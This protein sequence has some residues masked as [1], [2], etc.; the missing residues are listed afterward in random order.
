MFWSFFEILNTSFNVGSFHCLWQFIAHSYVQ[1]SKVIKCSWKLL[2]FGQLIIFNCYVKVG[3]YY[4]LFVLLVWDLTIGNY[5]ILLS[6]RICP[7]AVLVYMCQICKSIKVTFLCSFLVVLNRIFNLLLSAWIMLI[8]K[9]WGVD[10]IFFQK[11]AYFVHSFRILN[12]GWFD[13]IFNCFFEIFCQ[14]PSFFV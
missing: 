13:V 3:R 5:R 10:Q 7:D 14:I 9:L 6:N 11:L 12:W 8:K 1:C 4:E 2:L